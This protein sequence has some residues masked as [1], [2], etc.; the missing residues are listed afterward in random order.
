MNFFFKTFFLTVIVFTATNC[1]KEK[2][3]PQQGSSSHTV[4]NQKLN[5]V[6]THCSNFTHIKPKVDFLFLWD[7]SFS[8]TFIN[9]A[10]KQ[11]L[12][13][14]INFISE[15]F[16]YHILMAPLLGSGNDN[17]AFM[18]FTSKSVSGVDN[19]K[20]ED[21]S[22]TL[23]E[24]SAKHGEGSIE[25]GVQ[26]AIDLLKDNVRKGIFRRRGNTI[27][28]LMSNGDDNSWSPKNL[29]RED[30]INNKSQ[31]LL[32]IKNNFKS[33]EFRF[34]TITPHRSCP[35]NSTENY[36]GNFVYKSLS[37]KL[38]PKK[39]DAYNLCDVEDFKKLFDGIN[40][41]IELVIQGHKYNRWPVAGPDVKIAKKERM[42]SL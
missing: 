18:S 14:T 23:D 30:Y 32:T 16:D 1:G 20:L 8:A 22:K 38:N 27:V 40:E 13:N 3:A 9:D 10:T 15:H 29:A 7:N 4:G 35:P 6:V 39:N 12:N 33:K 21:A 31:A 34:I 19:I 37:K 42:E 25:A 41:F 28:V 17:A 11:A 36:E 2:F 26:R 24:I 5:P